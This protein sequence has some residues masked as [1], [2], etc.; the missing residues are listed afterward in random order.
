MTGTSTFYAARLIH[1]FCQ[2]GVHVT[3]ADSLRISGGKAAR[4]VAHR[5][6][7]PSLN[8][9]PEGYLTAILAELDRQ[10]YDLLLPAFEE[11]LLLSEHAAV[12]RQR[13]RLLLPQFS[14]MLSLHHKPSLHKLCE[15]LKLP[16]PPMVSVRSTDQLWAVP[17][18]IGFP[19]VVKR[20]MANSAVGLTSC[21]D[22]DGLKATFARISLAQQ[23]TDELPFVQKKIAGELISTLC[24]CCEG[25]KHRE[26]VYRTNRTFPQ[27]GGTAAHRESIEHPEIS[28]IADRLIAATNW[29]GFLGLD[30][31]VEQETKTPYLIDAN[32]RVN[33]AIHLG[34]LSGIDWAGVILELVAGRIPFQ[35]QSATGVHA[36]TWLL[37]FAWLLEGLLPRAGRLRDFP[38]RCWQYVRPQ[39]Q[40]HS[41]NDLRS[42]GESKAARVI[43]LQALTALGK[44]LMTGRPV[45]EILNQ[46]A[47]YNAA[48][49]REF[50]QRQ[51][52]IA[53]RKAA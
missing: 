6:Q 41:R 33:P 8:A 19:V 29:S 16:T 10:S 13:T 26:V 7:V 51:Q 27:A 28:R 36:H 2:R 48:T 34:I 43:S 38:A 45:G 50:C 40:V 15:S 1:E 14:A 42:I 49:A 9:D 24:F 25:R 12:I 30:F 44:S 20:P 31:L 17:Q 22:M 35:Q 4:N 11:S 39:W 3:A 23:P 53:V 18:L 47:N 46:H 21:E 37:D 32:V 52:E 5:L